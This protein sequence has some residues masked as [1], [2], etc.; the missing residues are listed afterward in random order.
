MSETYKQIH[1]DAQERRLLR[2]SVRRA[3]LELTREELQFAEDAAERLGT[4]MGFKGM[5]VLRRLTDNPVVRMKILMSLFRRVR[6]LAK[7]QDSDQIKF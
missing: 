4:A 3:E 1:A 5:D 2:M 7:L 6:D